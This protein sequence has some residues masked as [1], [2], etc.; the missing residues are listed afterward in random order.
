MQIVKVVIW[1]PSGKFAEGTFLEGLRQMPV[2][3]GR[4]AVLLPCDVD[5]FQRSGVGG[6]FMRRWGMGWAYQGHVASRGCPMVLHV[7]P[8]RPFI[9]WA[10]R[11]IPATRTM[12]EG[13][14]PE[15]DFHGHLR[16]TSDSSQPSALSGGL[17]ADSDTIDLSKLGPADPQGGWII[18]GRSRLSVVERGFFSFSLYGLAKGLKVLWS[19]V[20][21]SSTD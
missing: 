1:D 2:I 11:L 20:S 13:E 6:Y 16:L 4:G 9:H 18:R 3:E 17:S 8:D 21:Q 12:P 15:T 10:A 14:V 19:A 5:L 7:M